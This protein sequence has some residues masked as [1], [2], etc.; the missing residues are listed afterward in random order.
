MNVN[1]NNT[2]SASSIE[3]VARNVPGDERIGV[4]EMSDLQPARVPVPAQAPRP[5]T[6]SRR[7]IRGSYQ[8]SR[9]STSGST[10][11]LFTMTLLC[12]YTILYVILYS[13]ARPLIALYLIKVPLVDVY[14]DLLIATVAITYGL[15]FSIGAYYYRKVKGDEV[16]CT[17][18]LPMEIYNFVIPEATDR[19]IK[20]AGKKSMIY[21]AG[22]VV[23]ANIMVLNNSALDL[24]KGVASATTSLPV[25]ITGWLISLTFITFLKWCALIVVSAEQDYGELE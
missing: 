2:Q 20:I 18:L 12:L 22:F 21:M 15:D 16:S 14:S 6:H 9:A 23:A 7:N 19:E 1:L 10:Q 17:I 8:P 13:C 11:S 4:H 5:S 3:L 25:I 24:W